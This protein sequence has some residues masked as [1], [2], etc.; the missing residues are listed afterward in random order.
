MRHII[1]RF[2]DEAHFFRHLTRSS[3]RGPKDTLSFLGNFDTEAGETVRLTL[4][5]ANQAERYDVTMEV[6]GRRPSTLNSDAD[7]WRYEAV[8]TEDD[9][10]WLEMLA[11]KLS[12]M[13][14]MSARPMSLAA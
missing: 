7:L 3:R 11:S 5:V 14:R 13:Q 10:I 9:A 6:L 12:M 8:V 1:C 4:V 2:T